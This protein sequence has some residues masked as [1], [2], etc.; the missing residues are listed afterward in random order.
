MTKIFAPVTILFLFILQGCTGPG[1]LLEAPER[2]LD[3]YLEYSTLITPDYLRS[4]LEVIA[5]D[6]LKGRDTGSEGERIAAQ[7]LINHYE[8]LNIQPKGSVESSYMQPFKLNAERVDSLVYSSFQ[9]EGT[10]TLKHQRSVVSKNSPGDFLRLF[11]GATPFSGKIIFGGFGVNDAGRNVNHLDAEL[12]QNQWV[13]IFADYPTVVEGDTLV[14]PAITN[15]TRIGSILGQ[16]DAGGVLVVG[17][18]SQ[19]EFA[20]TAKINAKL[21]GEPENMR[22][23]YLD[24]STER[25]GFPNSLV[26]VSPELAVQILRLNSVDELH[27]LRDR[28]TDEI[29]EFTPSATSF[30]LDYTPYD[31]IVEVESNNVLAYIEGSDPELKDE[32][33]VLIA[34]YDHIGLSLPDERGNMINNGADDN[35]SGTV[36][37]MAIAETLKE[38]KL[39]G[40]GLDRSV[41]FLH[42]SAEEKGLLGSRY[43]SDHPVI[44]I[45]QTVTAFNADMIGRSDPEN[46]EAGTTDYVYLIGGEIISSKLDSLVTTANER[47]V[48]MRLDRKHNDLTDPNQFYRRS[49]HWNLGRLNVPFVFFFTGVHEDYHRPGDEVHKIEFDKY[50]RVVQLIYSSTVKVANYD[51]RPDVDNATFINITREIP[52]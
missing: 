40:S 46:I 49:D 48:D 28:L 39:N 44:P 9:I 42:V 25:D 5:H 15:N 37:L 1:E 14:N 50:S 12:M 23:Q 32:A 34:H 8:S 7:Y 3:Y 31:G 35:G 36:A 17:D 20:E 52:R 29:T 30:H 45:E 26:Q 27:D 21:L 16:M 33:I 51:G 43:Y 22:L 47:S 24:D 19:E 6:S 4:H 2:D 38:A 11:G 10:D 13:L 41:L 18:E